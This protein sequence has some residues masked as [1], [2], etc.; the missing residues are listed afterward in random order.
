MLSSSSMISC[1]PM[2]IV[3]ISHLKGAIAN[4][5]SWSVPA[6]VKAQNQIDDV[7]WLNTTDAELPHWKEIQ[8]FTKFSRVKNLER[9]K[10]PFNHP[11]LVVF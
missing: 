9:I 2:K 8:G 4:G 1:E 7:L 10:A 6:S 5:L 11:D 3:Y